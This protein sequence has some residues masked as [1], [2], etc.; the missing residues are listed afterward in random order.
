MDAI[1]KITQRLDCL[2][3]YYG[4]LKNVRDISFEKYVG[5]IKEKSAIERNFQLAIECCLDIAELFISDLRLPQPPEHRM[6]M[7]LLSENKI[8][9]REMAEKLANAVSFRNLL[10]HDYVEIDD[11]KAFENLKNIR[12]FDEFIK[13]VKKYLAQ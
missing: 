12:D 2:K 7:M 9:P 5:D 11:K 4:Y 10:V 1:D 3:Q 13:E 6:A 8:I